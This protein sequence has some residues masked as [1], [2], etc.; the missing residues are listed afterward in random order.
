M[1]GLPLTGGGWC[2]I[3][4]RQHSEGTMQEHNDVTDDELASELTK[5]G[6]TPL[7][8]LDDGAAEQLAAEMRERGGDA[9]AVGATVY[10]VISICP[11]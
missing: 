8:Q 6:Y 3:F 11:N 4:A 7:P 5:L 9:I 10:T 2:S 1:Y